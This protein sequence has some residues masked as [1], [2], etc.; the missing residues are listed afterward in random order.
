M[1]VRSGKQRRRCLGQSGAMP[2]CRRRGFTLME[3]MLVGGLMSLLVLLISGAWRGLGRSSAD[4]V[5][6]CRVAQEANLAAESLAHDFCGNL[7]DQVAGQ[8]ELGR[9][10]GRLVVGGTELRLCFDGNPVNDAA[11]WAVPDTVITYHVEQNRLIRSNQQTGTAL[12]VADNVNQMLLTEQAD[13]VTVDLTF[14]YRN[15]TRTFTIVAKD[16]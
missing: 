7:P 13:G 14:T 8:K 10:V 3:A 12:V 5:A 6:R 11:D 2:Q 1:M 16:P 4:A 15:M 9:L